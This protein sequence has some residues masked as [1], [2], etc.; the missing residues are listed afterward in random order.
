MKFST[1]IW[2]TTAFALMAG[3]LC[4]SLAE[5]RGGGGGGRGGGGRGAG[6]G[7]RGYGGRGGGMRT[8]GGGLGRYGGNRNDNS[9]EAMK[10]LEDRNA[11]IAERRKR[12]ADGEREANQE[13]RLAAARLDTAEVRSGEDVR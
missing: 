4:V 6:G 8:P 3:M 1:R 11:L 13:A 2:K 10:E 5:A 9:E 12:L 7:G